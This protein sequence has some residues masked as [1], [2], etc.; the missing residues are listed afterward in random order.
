ME[1]KNPLEKVLSIWGVFQK[2]SDGGLNREEIEDGEERTARPAF[3]MNM[4]Q[5][6]KPE[7]PTGDGDKEKGGEENNKD[8]EE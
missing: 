1:F 5:Q 6:N 8:Q 2:K 3:G 4:F 7:H